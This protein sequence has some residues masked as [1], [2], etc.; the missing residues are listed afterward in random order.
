MFGE[1]VQKG[2]EEAHLEHHGYCVG[3]ADTP[4]VVGVEQGPRGGVL[5]EGT[6]NG[7]GGDDHLLGDGDHSTWLLRLSAHNRKEV[8]G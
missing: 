5:G 7:E 4:I 6:V 2:V 3:E 8:Q 1:L